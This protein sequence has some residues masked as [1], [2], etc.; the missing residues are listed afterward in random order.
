MS[1]PPY[2]SDSVA[3]API[4][5]TYSSHTSQLL[6]LLILSGG[7]AFISLILIGL[8]ALGNALGNPL[9]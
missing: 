6:T 2:S 9:Y 7:L 5:S 1:F 4:A 3:I 8:V